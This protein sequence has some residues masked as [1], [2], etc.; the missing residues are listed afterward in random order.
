M[1]EIKEPSV[2]RDQLLADER[3]AERR[4][5]VAELEYQLAD[6]RGDGPDVVAEKRTALEQERVRSLEIR[7]RM[8]DG[9]EQ[10]R[11]YAAYQDAVKAAAAAGVPLEQFAGSG[12]EPT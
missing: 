1:D 8:I 6:A 9:Y 12:E 7:Q 10:W 3:A 5:V 2:T 11:R 4:V